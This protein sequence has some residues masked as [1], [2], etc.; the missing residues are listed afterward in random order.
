LGKT[1]F[2]FEKLTTPLLKA[3]HSYFEIIPDFNEIAEATKNEKIFLWSLN[4]PLQTFKY[5][6]IVI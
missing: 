5:I 1:I 4:K 3:F 2:S 6:I